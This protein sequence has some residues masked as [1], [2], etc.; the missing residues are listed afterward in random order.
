MKKTITRRSSSREPP[1]GFAAAAEQS[2]PAIARRCWKRLGFEEE[3]D[4]RRANA[5]AGLRLSEGLH[6][7]GRKYSN[8]PASSAA[9][10]SSASGVGSPYVS[11][12]TDNW[13]KVKTPV[14]P[15][16]KREAEEDWG[17]LQWR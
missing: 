4:A 8:T 6:G 10:A 12:R 9:R 1:F 5:G 16:V 11:G 14:A 7:E 2:R 15:A 13:I 17:K 3:A